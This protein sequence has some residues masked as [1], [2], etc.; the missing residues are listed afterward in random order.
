[1]TRCLNGTKPFSEP[2]IDYYYDYHWLDLVNKFQLNLNKKKTKNHVKK[3][4]LEA[5]LQPF[6]LGLMC[7]D[8]SICAT[9]TLSIQIRVLFAQTASVMNM[10]Y[11]PHTYTSGG[12][13]LIESPIYFQS[14][15]DCACQQMKPKYF[16]FD[17]EFETV[18]RINRH[19]RIRISS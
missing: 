17:F 9:K 5:K 15:S 14:K 19:S 11:K 16:D 1:M 13:L 4:N 8:T 10:N 18:P 6:C 3:I 12:C 2:V 7:F